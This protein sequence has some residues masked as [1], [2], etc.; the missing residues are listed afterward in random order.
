ML[1]DW[2]ETFFFWVPY[3]CLPEK[4]LQ[5]VDGLE[6]FLTTCHRIVSFRAPPDM[7]AKGNLVFHSLQKRHECFL[8]RHQAQATRDHFLTLHPHWWSRCVM[9]TSSSMHFC[10]T[11]S[12]NRSISPTHLL[13]DAWC[14]FESCLRKFYQF[15]FTP[16]ERCARFA[17]CAT[18]VS[19][20]WRKWPVKNRGAP[21]ILFCSWN[22]KQMIWLP[23][24]IMNV[25]LQN[26]IF[27]VLYFKPDA[28]VTSTCSLC[29]SV[30]AKIGFCTYRAGWT[31][32][33][34]ATTKA[35]VKRTSRQ[36]RLERHPEFCSKKKETFR[37]NILVQIMSEMVWN[38]RK[39]HLPF[40]RVPWITNL[41]WIK[42][43]LATIFVK[44][45]SCP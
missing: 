37:P 36:R 32:R 15:V 4:I 31:E 12:R 24:G 1:F 22:K 39:D 6:H 28:F 9:N 35:Q 34:P 41:F 38:T 26:V 2:P 20:N 25:F 3:S 8:W 29:E 18:L 45:V 33:L 43:Y 27:C 16:L 30:S 17:V 21:H 13:A 7:S 40:L 23:S 11:E 19:Q 5:M 14:S 44:N 42:T 10:A